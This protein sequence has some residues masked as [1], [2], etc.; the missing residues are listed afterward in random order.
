M[1]GWHAKVKSWPWMYT[2]NGY[3]NFVDKRRSGGKHYLHM[4][5]QQTIKGKQ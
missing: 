1:P 5:G 3:K 2:T 4:D